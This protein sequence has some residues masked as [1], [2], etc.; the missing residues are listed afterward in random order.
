MRIHELYWL[1]DSDREKSDSASLA[2]QCVTV[3]ETP[4]AIA[5]KRSPSSSK[6]ELVLTRELNAPMI[7][8]RIGCPIVT[9]SGLGL[10]LDYTVSIYLCIVFAVEFLAGANNFCTYRSHVAEAA[11]EI[12]RKNL[13][14]PQSIL[15]L[16]DSN[17]R[18]KEIRTL[19]SRQ[20]DSTG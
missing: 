4:S 12:L 9:L 16:K 13:T 2:A 1:M 19:C 15:L 7:R 14:H 17:L 3:G 11:D 8:I 6:L 18:Q 5:R 20:N 10:R